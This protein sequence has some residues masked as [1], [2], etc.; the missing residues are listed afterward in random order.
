M[1]CSEL[2]SLKGLPTS[3]QRCGRQE[4]ATQDSRQALSQGEGGPL[5]RVITA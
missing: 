3:D 1:H 4:R 5:P 2:L